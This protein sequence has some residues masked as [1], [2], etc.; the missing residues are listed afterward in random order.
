[1]KANKESDRRDFLKSS[2][3]ALLALGTAGALSASA[4]HHGKPTGS[5]ANDPLG[6]ATVSFGGWM[7][8]PPLDRFTALPPPSAN[9]HELIPHNARIKAGGYVNFIISG[10][11]VV[12]IYD[13]GTRPEDINT[14]LLVPGP[15]FGPPIINDPN[16]R[17]YRGIDPVISSGPPPIV[18]LD[19]VEVVHFENPGRYLVICG[20]LPHFLEGM[21]GYVTVSPGS[22]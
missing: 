10:L 3:A 4:Q 12:V 13:D 9:H 17:V 8:D 11:H 19:R 18:N 20:V 21:F 7:T 14:G 5:P 15:R 6:S 22:R 2:G 16:R 1:M